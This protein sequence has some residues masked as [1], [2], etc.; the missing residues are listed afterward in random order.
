MGSAI[1]KEDL[2]KE[3]SLTTPIM[4]LEAAIEKHKC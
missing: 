1:N 4:T 2:V 3:N